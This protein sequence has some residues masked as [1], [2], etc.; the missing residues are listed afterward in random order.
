MTELSEQSCRTQDFLR[1]I[2]AQG[3]RG[4]TPDQIKAA[5][6]AAFKAAYPLRPS[7]KGRP[8]LTVPMADHDI[9][10]LIEMIFI[11]MLCPYSNGQLST[12]HSVANEVVK[13]L[14][15][16]H[17]LDTATRRLARKFKRYFPD[18]VELRNQFWQCVVL[19][20]SQ[21][22]SCNGKVDERDLGS[23]IAIGTRKGD[24]GYGYIVADNISSWP[25]T[26]ELAIDLLS[27]QLSYR[28]GGIRI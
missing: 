19:S 16:R 7:R 27:R 10:E 23:C 5:F 8:A 3:S 28:L 14:V 4:A 15:K 6:A 22:Q 13:P 9:V 20:V 12:P 2:N 24:T 17:E 25:T 18:Y 11:W 26:A 1:L 21:R